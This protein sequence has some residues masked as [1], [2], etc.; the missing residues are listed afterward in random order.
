MMAE[1]KTKKTTESP[2]DFLNKIVD[3]QKRADAFII[4]EL[5]EKITH[6]PAKMWSSSIVGFGEVKLKYSSGREVEWMVC[7]FSPRKQ[8]IVI[9]MHEDFP[10]KQQLLAQLGKHKTGKSCLYLNNLREVNL[11]VLENYIS[12]GV[13]AT[14][15]KK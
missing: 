15:N 7:G 14:L 1:I 4:M 2:I 9:Y 11:R 13:T 6:S 5:M 10:E 12:A 8:N 3:E